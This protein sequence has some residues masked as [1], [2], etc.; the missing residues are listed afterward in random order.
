[1][2]ATQRGERSQRH[3]RQISCV[4]HAVERR[5]GVRTARKVGLRD[6]E[7]ARPPRLQRGTP[8]PRA[9]PGSLAPSI[10]PSL[11]PQPCVS[12][13][14]NNWAVKMK[15]F[16]AG[17]K[18]K[19]VQ[20]ADF[21]CSVCPLDAQLEKPRQG[22]MS[23]C[24]RGTNWR[25]LQAPAICSA[26]GGKWAPARDTDQPQQEG[27]DQGQHSSAPGTPASSHTVSSLTATTHG[28]A[29]RPQTGMGLR[30]P[31]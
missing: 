18:A 22:L 16:T 10:S 17:S 31:G 26:P 14:E 28:R 11:D 24:G 23:V 29:D 4:S 19:T 21:K 12:A 3:Q 5:K 7:R 6:G 25:R 8:D 9:L 27:P 1:M 30:T 15:E 20:L 2:R 13:E